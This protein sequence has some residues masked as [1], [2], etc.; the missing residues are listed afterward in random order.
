MPAWRITTVYFN[1]AE[2]LYPRNAELLGQHAFSYIGLR[3]FP[4]ALRKLD[5][6]LDITPHDVDTLAQKASIAQAQGDLPRAGLRP[7][8][9]VGDRRAANWNLFSKNSRKIFSSLPIS[10]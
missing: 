1:E 9:K 10:R 7:R 8:R 5:Q 2:R 4:E 3:R 6:V